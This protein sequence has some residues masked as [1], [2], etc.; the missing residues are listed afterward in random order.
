[1]PA[2]KIPM[3]SNLTSRLMRRPTPASMPA[4]GFTLVELLVVIAILGLLISILLPSLGGARKL[5]RRTLCLTHVR[6]LYN[7]HTTYLMQDNLFP[8]LN[9][10]EEDGAWQY[11]YL[12]FDGE[13]YNHNFGPLLRGQYIP[14]LEQLY[15]PV[16]TDPFH[17]QGTPGNPWPARK[18]FDTRAGY[19][20]RYL[21]SGLS[22]SRL[23]PGMAVLADVMHLPKVIRSAHVI[24]L[25]AAYGDGHA[26]WVP[27]PGIFT[28]NE[29]D[30]PFDP[31]DNLP[32]V[33]KIWDA[34]EGRKVTDDEDED[35]D[36]DDGDP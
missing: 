9:N 16:Q 5:A 2:T 31:M 20:R 6:E 10:E 12:V 27:D 34:I 22:Y 13:D 8:A 3:P 17:S 4:P 1:M 30:T 32:I 25:N 11:N 14:E 29:L 19:A 26:N 35:E 23:K 7:A 36:A 15:C 28:D 21:L 33:K 18:G 24:G